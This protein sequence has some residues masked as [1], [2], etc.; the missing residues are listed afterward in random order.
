MT[1]EPGR[2]WDGDDKHTDTPCNSQPAVI[3][4][5]RTEHKRAD[6]FNDLGDWL[7]S[8]ECFEVGWHTFGWDECATGERQREDNNE[9]Q[10]L[11]RFHAFS[12]DTHYGH[13]P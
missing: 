9:C 4:D 1:E 10:P 2:K 5:R 6:S 3:T 8:G 7:V 12:F 13:Y 11:H